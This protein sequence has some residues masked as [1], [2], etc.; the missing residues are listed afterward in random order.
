MRLRRLTPLYDGAEKG[1][2]IVRYYWA[3]YLATH[4]AD[5]HGR[6]LEIGSVETLRQW[7]GERLTDADAI[8]LTPHGPDVR[9]VADLMRADDVPGESYDCFVH[10]FSLHMMYDAEAALYHSVRLLKPGGTLL[11]SAVCVDPYHPNGLDMGTGQPLFSFWT[12]TPLL[13]E[14]MLRRIGLR[15]GDYALTVF[16]NLFARVAYE[17]NMAAEELTPRELDHVDPSHPVL[18]G[19]RVRRPAGWVGVKPPY[20]DPWLPSG[21]PSRWSPTRRHYGEPAG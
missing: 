2:P 11:L 7:G 19:V 10:Q 5:I 15:D 12:F 8:D 14:N 13:L 18:I 21:P 16:G 17:F 4:R 1:T 6:G 3:R 20:R 9:V